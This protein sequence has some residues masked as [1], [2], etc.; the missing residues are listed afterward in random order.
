MRE[1]GRFLG[2]RTRP[3]APLGLMGTGAL[4]DALGE[5]TRRQ[6]GE[7]LCATRLHIG[8]IDGGGRKISGRLKL[9]SQEGVHQHAGGFG[10]FG[11]AMAQ[12]GFA[13][14]QAHLA[15]AERGLGFPK[16]RHPAM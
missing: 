12:V 9:R 10:R 7:V 8:A 15:A 14:E 4:F 13:G 3:F 6:H 2:G 5:G 11:H 16:A 1:P